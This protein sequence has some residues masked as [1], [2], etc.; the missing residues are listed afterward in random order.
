[1]PITKGRLEKNL[2]VIRRAVG[3]ACARGG[4]TAED[5]SIVAITKTA[6]LDAVKLLVE[7]G[8]TEL[9]ESRAQQLGERAAE[10]AGWLARRRSEPPGPVRWHMVGHLQRNKVKGVLEW[11]TTVHS[12]DSLRLAEEISERAGRA[13]KKIDLLLQVNCSDEPQKFGIVVG[14]A[15]HLAELMG[16]MSNVRLV[17]LMTMAA[18]AKNPEDARPAFRRLRELFEEIRGEKIAGEDFRHLSMGMSQDYAVAVEEGAT[19]L[20]IGSA[21]FEQPD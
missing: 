9:A 16:T 10:L 18:K 11:A 5:V 21:L 2:A 4:R 14:A 20:R 6:N 17:G 7:C 15:K 1:M 8:L 12:V 13:G 3:Q 19:L